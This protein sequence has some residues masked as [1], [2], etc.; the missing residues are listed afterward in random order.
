MY[1]TRFRGEQGAEVAALLHDAGALEGE[2]YVPNRQNVR[3]VGRV[4]GLFEQ[5]VALGENTVEAAGNGSRFCPSG[6]GLRPRNAAF[7]EG[8]G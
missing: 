3:Y 1:F 7:P 5:V 8:S 4:F 2:L 6:R